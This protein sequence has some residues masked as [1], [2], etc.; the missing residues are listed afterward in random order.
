M[1]KTFKFI[2]VMI[3]FLSLFF[4]A[5]SFFVDTPCKIDEDCP[6]F[7]RPWSQIVKYYCIADQCFY[8]IKHI[9]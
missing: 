2:H 7:Q 5:E 8:Y 9:K 6:Q 3:L 4:V 1:T